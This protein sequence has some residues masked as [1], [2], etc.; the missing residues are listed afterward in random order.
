M[1]LDALQ[2]QATRWLHKAVAF[3]DDKLFTGN[4]EWQIAA[5]VLAVLA[6]MMLGRPLTRRFRAYLRD[7]VQPGHHFYGFL[8]SVARALRP[9]PV[10]LL[11]L[12]GMA[13]FQQ[14]EA[15]RWLLNTAVSL[16]LAWIIITVFAS[17]IA[18]AFFS[19]VFSL[20]VWA[21]AALHVLRLLEPA[22]ELLASL[23]MEFGE[24]YISILDVFKGALVFAILAFFARVATKVIDQTM[25][26]QEAVTASVRVLVTK[27]AKILLIALAF[28]M[29]IA[30]TGINLTSLAVIGGAV[31]VGLGFGLQKIFANLISGFI[32]LMDK[33][34]KPGDTIEVEGVYGWIT[35][36][37]ARYVTVRTRDGKDYLIPNEELII[38]KVIN[39]SHSNN[40]IRL[41][42]PVGVSYGSDIRRALDILAEAAV[43]NERVLADP[44]PAPRLMEF[45]DSSVNLELRIWI[46]DPWNG[47]VNVRSEILLAV[48]DAFHEEGIEIPFPQRD[49]HLKTMPDGF[50]GKKTDH[51]DFGKGEERARE[52]P[53]GEEEG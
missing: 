1:N 20:V 51:P 38:N 2:A 35:S 33:S 52:E 17:L 53:A 24:S 6:G 15:D 34:I 31:G 4:T 44:E 16:T 12:V 11:L 10:L 36:L 28:L 14:A 48:W 26:G 43:A 42:I 13:A 5:V 23:G 25:S 19:R 9:I 29:A 21:A 30:S 49:L 37:N 47:V 45:G 22:T 50:R 41:R 8:H 40:V 18:N 39:W 3:A 27:T 46:A 32:L 7:H